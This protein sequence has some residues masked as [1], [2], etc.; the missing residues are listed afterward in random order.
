MKRPYKIVKNTSKWPLE[1]LVPL[2]DLAWDMA[3]K[4]RD[5][6]GHHPRYSPHSSLEFVERNC[7]YNVTITHCSCT[8]R[9]R[10]WRSRCL[11]R[12]GHGNHTWPVK[13]NYWRYKDMPDYE[14]RSWRE[15]FVHL[16][17]HEFAH[18][19][20]YSGKRGGEEMCELTAWDAIDAY[21]KRQPEIDAKIDTALKRAQERTVIALQRIEERQTE[22]NTPEYKLAVLDRKE[23]VWLRKLRLA[24]S[25]MKSIKRSRAAI[26]RWQNF[27]AG[28][29][30][31]EAAT[32]GPPCSSTTTSTVN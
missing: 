14:A 13:L 17:A 12:I 27:K 25:K 21:R 15:V 28:E 1:V 9:G 22:R 16:A 32:A 11:L 6:L 24:L 18:L 19:T 29:A 30:Y 31:A 26:I 7:I 10:A 3:W 20:G 8:Y 2:I 23:K 5:P 4:D